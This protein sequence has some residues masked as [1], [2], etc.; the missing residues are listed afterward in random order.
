MPAF[1]DAPALVEN[2]CR[3]GTCLPTDQSAAFVRDCL[4]PWP[5]CGV[6][7]AMKVSFLLLIGCMLLAGCS[8][9]TTHQSGD[10]G[11]LKHIYVEHLLNDNYRM[12]ESIAAELKALGYD[13]SAGPLTM[14]PD[15]VDAIITYDAR[16][17]WDFKSYVIELNVL[18]KAN[19][20]EK[21]LGTGRYYQASITTKSPE[22]TVHEV[23]TSLFKHR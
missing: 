17:A 19:F 1:P 3:H 14:M 21:I 12:D 6:Y 8:S 4:P 20:T 23:I 7:A 10:L 9:L 5:F 22:E 16:T 13:A 15:N 18:V 11:S 2:S